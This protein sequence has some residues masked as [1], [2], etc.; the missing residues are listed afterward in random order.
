[1]E[2]S[3]SWDAKQFSASQEIPHILWNPKV[4]Y[5]IHKCSPPV[6]IL[7]QLDPVHTPHP[8]LWSS[9]LI[10]SSHRRLGLP[11]GLFPSGFPTK[12]LYT[13]LVSPTRTTCPARLILLVVI[14]RKIFGEQ[15][16]SLSS[17]LCSFLHSPVTSSLL[18]SNILLNTLFSNTL[19]L[20]SSLNVSDQVSHPHKTTGKMIVLYILIFTFSDRKMES[21]RFCTKW[22]QAFPDLSL[23]L[24]SSWIQLVTQQS[25]EPPWPWKW[26]RYSLPKRRKY[27][28]SDMASRHC[29]PDLSA[30]L[31]RRHSLSFVT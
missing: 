31:T 14:I 27:W 1:M 30:T 25:P 24:I 10:L 8:T 3:N 29:R 16:R 2:Q 18:R 6:L 12:T 28:P 20:R 15:Y 13:P 5:R 22:Y 9:I 17:S 26:K 19:S 4:H 23:L 11:S 21:K 7:C